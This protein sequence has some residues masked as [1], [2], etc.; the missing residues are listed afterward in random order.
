[1]R[2]LVIGAGLMGRWHAESIRRVGGSVVAIVDADVPRAITLARAIGGGCAPVGVLDD[3][4]ARHSPEVVHVCTPD[5]THEALVERSLDAGCHVLVEKPFAVDGAATERLLAHAARRSR[6][7]CPV[8][9]FLFQPG[10]ER[11]VALA[12]AGELGDVLHV[13][14]LACSTGAD[15]MSGDDPRRRVALEIVPHA[16]ALAERLAP[17]SLDAMEW[18]VAEPRPGELRVLADGGGL[19]LAVTISMAARPTRN[20]VT[21]LGT[22]ASAELD[23]FHGFAVVDRARAD[24]RWKIARPFVVGRRLVG[25]ATVNLAR[26]AARGERAYP[27]LRELVRRFHAAAQSG[28]APPIA[29]GETI[30]VARARDRIT[31]LLVGDAAGRSPLPSGAREPVASR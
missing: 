16:L 14:A 3:A 2:A 15:A 19:S 6:L 20:G 11:V 7:V 28:G 31:K 26:R 18:A 9:Q 24:R 17:G 29:P 10:A 1:M 12:R 5:A 8:H 30:A 23:L 25:A 22:L 4:F 13:E 21:V 27:G